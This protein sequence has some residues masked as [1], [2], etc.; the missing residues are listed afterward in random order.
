MTPVF[1]EILCKDFCSKKSKKFDS[2][3]NWFSSIHECGGCYN[4]FD[5][6]DTLKDHYQ[7]CQK[8]KMLPADFDPVNPRCSRLVFNYNSHPSS[9]ITCAKCPKTSFCS[10]VGL[11]L[12]YARDHSIFVNDDHTRLSNKSK[13]SIKLVYTP[14]IFRNCTHLWL[15]SG[16]QRAQTPDNCADRTRPASM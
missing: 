15:G 13:N 5:H 9:R 11:R 2:L 1:H 4:T 8:G 14:L 16:Y 10:F 3:N 6:L 7:H 12:H